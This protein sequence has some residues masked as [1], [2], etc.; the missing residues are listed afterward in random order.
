VVE[1]AWPIPD[2]EGTFRGVVAEGPV[3]TRLARRARV[4]R[5]EIRRWRDGVIADIVHAVDSPRRL[6]TD[7]LVARRMLALVPDAPTPVWGRDEIGAGEMWN[8]NS[9][10]SWLV[11]RSGIDLDS[12]HPPPRGRAPG[13]DAGVWY[14]ETMRRQRRAPLP[15]AANA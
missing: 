2:G 11:A 4:L 3:G 14:A 7:L 9:L 12:V 15:S 1:Q 8:S 10:V 13:W 6:S 5:Y